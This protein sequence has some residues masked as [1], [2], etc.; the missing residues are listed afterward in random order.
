MKIMF[1]TAV[2]ALF[3][4]AVSVHGA[5]SWPPDGVGAT[6]DGV[7]LKEDA[8][9]VVRIPD[10]WTE[11]PSVVRVRAPPPP[12]VRRRGRPSLSC[13]RSVPRSAFPSHRRFSGARA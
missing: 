2:A 5:C 13:S 9:G 8:D 10:D 1:T 12:S 11:I 4:N 7:V 3:A 6:V